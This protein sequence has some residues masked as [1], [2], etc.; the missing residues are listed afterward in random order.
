[1]C[2]RGEQTVFATLVI[3]SERGWRLARSIN[4]L[5]AGWR[6]KDS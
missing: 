2:A 6:R 3:E 1:M 4:D 5:A